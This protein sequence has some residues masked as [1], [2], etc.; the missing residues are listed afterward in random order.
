MAR[1]G[2]W[3]SQAAMFAASSA[4]TSKAMFTRWYP[5]RRCRS[6]ASCLPSRKMFFHRGAVPV[7]VLGGHWRSL[8]PLP[9]PLVVPDQIVGLDIRRRD[10]LGGVLHEYQHAA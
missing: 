9:V 2:R 10:G 4:P 3:G 5:E 7:P 1:A 8:Q 6:A